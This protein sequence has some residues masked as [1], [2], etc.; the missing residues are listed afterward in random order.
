V[1]GASLD[2][3]GQIGPEAEAAVPA[4]IEALTEANTRGAAVEALGLLGPK[5]QPAVPALEPLLQG[6]DVA[7]GWAS[8]AA[9]V[10][11]GGPGARAGVRFF[12]KTA[13]PNGGREL[14][15]AENI[16][17][18]PAAREAL[19]EMLDAVRDPALRDT[20]VQIVRDKNFLPLT[21]EQVADARRFL[22][23]PE[24][25][26]RCVASWVL[27]CR[28]GQ[29]G[30]GVDTGDVIAVQRQTLQASDPWARC[31]AARL[32]GSLGPYGQDA[33]PALTAVLEDKD[34]GVRKA[35]AAALKNIRPR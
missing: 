17:V 29:P 12:L 22:E 28:R 18:A 5:A 19:R 9:L 31:Q 4:L 26:V 14:Y 3:L 27:Y 34:E 16:L 6:D 20:A 21:K 11:I 2:A 35:A 15:D 25:G 7:V 24:P 23:D 13:N 33:I 30:V 1:T 10:R 32:L 8:A